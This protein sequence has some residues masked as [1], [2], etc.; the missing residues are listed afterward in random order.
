MPQISLKALDGT[1]SIHRF[2]ADGGIPQEIIGTSFFAISKTDDELSV[3]CESAI[4]LRSQES[5]DQWSCLKVLGPLDFSLTGILA[6]ISTAL[7]DAEISIFAIS[8]YDTD[9]ILVNFEDLK[10]AKI[11]LSGSGYFVVE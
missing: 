3:V 4:Q 10:A 9:Y 11:A 6:G 7:A 5:V 1:F 8:T 2:P